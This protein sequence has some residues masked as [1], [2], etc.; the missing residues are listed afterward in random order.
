MQ[1]ISY[2]R[3]TRSLPCEV[4]PFP[5][6]SRSL[7]YQGL[8]CEVLGVDKDMVVVPVTEMPF[9]FVQ[10]TVDMLGAD[11]VGCSND[12]PLRQ[13][14]YLFD[15]IGMNISSGSLKQW[16]ISCTLRCKRTTRFRFLK[17]TRKLES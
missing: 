14:S 12:T 16:P 8:V 9:Q 7:C 13:G 6:L 3:G 11:L 2:H 1:P 4:V 10:V 5:L 17:S 15:A